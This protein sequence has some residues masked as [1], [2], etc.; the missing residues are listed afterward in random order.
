MQK[1]NAQKILTEKGIIS[2]EGKASMLAE[3][4]LCD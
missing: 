3:C 2:K 4:Y 1:N